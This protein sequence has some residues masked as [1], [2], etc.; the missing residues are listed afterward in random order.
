MKSS[1]FLLSSF[2]LF[3][4]L[5][6]SFFFL[7]SSLSSLTISPFLNCEFISF[8]VEMSKSSRMD[9]NRA[10]RYEGRLVKRRKTLSE[11]SPKS[12]KRETTSKVGCQDSCSIL[13]KMIGT[14]NSTKRMSGSV[15]VSLDCE[16]VGVGSDGRQ[17]VLARVCMIDGFGG[18]L[19]DS[20]VRPVER[21]TDF[22]TRITGIRHKDLFGPSSKAIT[23]TE[24][25]KKCADLLEGKLLIG[26]S[27]HHDLSVLMLSHPKGMTVDVSVL[28]R[29]LGL[30][31]GEKRILALKELSKTHLRVSIQCSAHDPT[32]DSLA[33]LL[34]YWKFEK[35]LLK[36][37]KS[38]MPT[39]CRKGGGRWI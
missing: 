31:E 17:S 28:P 39:P 33:A 24:A 32:E 11:P 29:I 38:G 3:F 34:L 23:L 13:R 8:S 7:L 15:L 36:D 2:L 9:G 19:L 5:L 4:F 1:S 27:V 37:L 18:L 20:F 16:M 6:S 22:R 10:G 30:K 25:Q 21:V 14:V 35:I 26:H 12:P